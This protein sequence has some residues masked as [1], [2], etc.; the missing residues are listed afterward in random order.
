MEK[1]NSVFICCLFHRKQYTVI[2]YSA[3]WVIKIPVALCW[4]SHNLGKEW[5]WALISVAS[6]LNYHFQWAAVALVP[7]QGSGGTMMPFPP[8][9]EKEFWSALLEAIE[10][11]DIYRQCSTLNLS[12]PPITP[13]G[14]IIFLIL[15]PQSNVILG[16]FTV[17]F[18]EY[19][20]SAFWEC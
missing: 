17:L 5:R 7:S 15:L 11:Y 10:I 19:P 1:F 2:F 6:A 12:S 16:T 20:H 13:L 9:A 8:V 4:T 14:V 3:I 18:L